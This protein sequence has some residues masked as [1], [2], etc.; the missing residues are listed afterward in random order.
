MR[1]KVD[2]P[3]DFRQARVGRIVKYL[4]LA[5]L[6]FWGGWGLINPIFALFIVAKVP[7][8]TAFTVGAAFA[9][10]WLVK[11]VW[12]IPVAI[13][14][15][16]HEGERDDFNALI[17]G[18][19]AAGFT[20]LVFPLVNNMFWLFVVVVLQ[21][22]AYGLYTPSW[23]AIFSRHLDKD[24]YA[25][26]WSLDS[27]TIGVASGIAAFVGGAIANLWGF[28]AV[29]ILTGIASLVSAVLLFSAPHL[30]LPRTITPGPVIPEHAPGEAK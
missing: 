26:D 21:A 4:I 23:S 2:I 16:K 13:F 29:F 19:T 5:D 6:F 11:A 24:H 22:L 9:V 18:L 27:T 10:Y 30:V 7:E 25:F 17:L 1:F 8:A 28:D 14:L 15:D 3:L 12:Q 20:A